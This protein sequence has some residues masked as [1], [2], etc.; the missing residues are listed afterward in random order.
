MASVPITPKVGTVISHKGLG[1]LHT[2]VV[3]VQHGIHLVFE[4]CASIQLIELGRVYSAVL[5]DGSGDISHT[6]FSLSRLHHE[7]IA[8]VGS[9]AKSPFMER[10]THIYKN[11]ALLLSTRQLTWHLN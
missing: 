10:F 3:S 1:L 8:W 7:L 2:V 11:I 6:E 5:I 4:S 9:I